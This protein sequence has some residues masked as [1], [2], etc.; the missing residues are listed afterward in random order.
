M[1]FFL[2][3]TNFLIQ[4]LVYFSLKLIY[5]FQHNFCIYSFFY[6]IVDCAILHSIFVPIRLSVCLYLLRLLVCFYICQFFCFYICQF[7]CFYMC[8][9]LPLWSICPCS[10][11]RLEYPDLAGLILS[12][13]SEVA[14]TERGSQHQQEVQRVQQLHPQH[15]GQAGSGRNKVP[16]TAF[17]EETLAFIQVARYLYLTTI[18]RQPIIYKL[19]PS[20]VAVDFFV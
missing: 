15:R 7:F 8:Q 14:A 11:I 17:R 9:F 13:S 18:Y 1:N 4:S 5:F 2:L 12:C 19:S 3:F 6:R 10:W 16:P 20:E